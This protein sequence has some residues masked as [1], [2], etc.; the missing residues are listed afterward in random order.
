MIQ[1]AALMS[2]KGVFPLGKDS[3]PMHIVLFMFQYALLLR[4]NDHS[5]SLLQSWRQLLD[6]NR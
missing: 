2:R 5:R 6:A 4:V 1:L 3:F